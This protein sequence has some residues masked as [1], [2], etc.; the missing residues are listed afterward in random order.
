MGDVAG[1]GGWTAGQ[2]GEVSFGLPNLH[3]VARV[4]AKSF[5]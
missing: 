3:E 4:E 2:E 1:E 5:I